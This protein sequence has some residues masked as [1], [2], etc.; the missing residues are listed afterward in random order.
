[1]VEHVTRGVVDREKCAHP[2]NGTVAPVSTY[3]PLPAAHDPGGHVVC[4]RT[5]DG[6]HEETVTVRWENEGYTVSGRVGRE[7]V[8]Y[9]LRLSPTWQTRQ[10]ILFRDLDEPDL[11]LATDGHGRWG[12]MNG[13]HRTELDGC[14][15]LD[16][17][18]T[19]FTHSLAI[20]RLPLL[21]GHTAEIPVVTVDTETLEVRAE[22]HRYTRHE[23]GRWTVG[24]AEGDVELSVDEHGLVLEQAEHYR[25]V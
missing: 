22:S 8:E 10:F 19:P 18:C 11:W 14:Y 16:L 25:R 12:E 15:D 7:Q 17:R 21:D 13:A 5:W 2:G 1:V 9:V 4:W 24:R 6:L 20:R 3:T 23:P